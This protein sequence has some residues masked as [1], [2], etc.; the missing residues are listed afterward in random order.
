[1]Q[2]AANGHRQNRPLD[3]AWLD[4]ISSV[5]ADVTPTVVDALKTFQPQPGAQNSANATN[6]QAAAQ[7]GAF[8]DLTNV[9]AATV[10]YV[11]DALRDYQPQQAQRS[12]RQTSDDVFDVARLAAPIAIAAL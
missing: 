2:N 9:V 6:L 10:P 4:S 11:L 1:L 3:R 8:D 12:H 7:R 5:V